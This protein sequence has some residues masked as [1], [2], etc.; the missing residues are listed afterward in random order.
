MK[1]NREKHNV[2]GA[3]KEDKGLQIFNNPQFGQL[4]THQDADGKIWFCLADVCRALEIGNPRQ[5][6]TRLRKEGVISND[7]STPIISQGVNTGKTKEMQM[8][9]IDEPNV[10]RCIFQSRKKE[11]EQFQNWVFEEVLP[12]IRQTGGYIATK[13]GETAEELMARALLVAQDAINRQRQELEH[14]KV[15]MTLQEKELQK[16]APKVEYYD[17]V[18]QPNS[19]YTFSQIAK[20]VGNRIIIGTDAHESRSLLD[21]KTYH[22]ARQHLENLGLSITEDITFLR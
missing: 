6:K 9:F 17:K 2:V 14:A 3:H 7:V 8:T 15:T 18:L 16:Q 5:V 22:Q 1:K 11:A 12:A 13:E 4:R 20:E 10:Y 21:M 19:T